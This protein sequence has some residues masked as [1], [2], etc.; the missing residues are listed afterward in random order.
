[1]SEKAKVKVNRPFCIVC[2]RFQSPIE[3]NAGGYSSDDSDDLAKF[4][5]PE[6]WITSDDITPATGSPVNFKLFELLGE[7]FKAGSVCKDCNYLLSQ[8]DA[9]KFQ[10]DHL[11]VS[12]RQRVRL[13]QDSCSNYQVDLGVTAKD[14]ESKKAEDKAMNRE[15]KK[16]ARTA[17][18]PNFSV[19]WKKSNWLGQQSMEHHLTEQ[20]QKMAMAKKELKERLEIKSL[21]ESTPISSE[22]EELRQGWEKWTN[23]AFVECEL[24]KAEFDHDVVFNAERVVLFYK[25]FIYKECMNKAFVTD[26]LITRWVCQ[27]CGDQLITTVNCDNVFKESF[28]GKH[29]HSFCDIKDMSKNFWGDKIKAIHDSKPEASNEDILETLSSSILSLNKHSKVMLDLISKIRTL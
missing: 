3:E 27:T 18:W 7:E 26:D 11:T 21:D 10:A 2:K 19:T 4:R 1:M 28:N 23:K 29:N 25:G 12:L 17:L 13:H 15:Y 9:L 16:K 22:D 14:V 8:L 6:E 20:K 24:A 5:L